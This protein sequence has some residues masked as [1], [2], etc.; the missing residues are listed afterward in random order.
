MYS[1]LAIIK[2]ENGRSIHRHVSNRTVSKILGLA[3]I[4]M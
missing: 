3:A 1:V 2:D 4:F